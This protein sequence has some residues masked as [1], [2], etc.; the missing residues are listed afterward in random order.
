MV[1]LVECRLL[2]SNSTIKAASSDIKSLEDTTTHNAQVWS[3]FQIKRSNYTL[4]F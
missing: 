4:I 3:I 2:K 1:V